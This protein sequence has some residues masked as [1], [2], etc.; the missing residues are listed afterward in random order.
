MGT[1]LT[2]LTPAT[3][4]DALIKV[5]DNGPL[6]GTAKVLS[7][8][9]GNDSIL[10]LSTTAVGIGTTTPSSPLSIVNTIALSA[11]ATN[12]RIFNEAYTINNSGAQT[13]T[14]T[15]IFLNAT[16]TNLNGQTH[17]LIDLQTAS[18]SKFY[19]TNVGFVNANS[20]IYGGGDIRIAAAGQYFW[21]GRSGIKS[22][23]DGNITLLNNANTAFSLLQLGGTTSSFPSIKRNGTAIDFRLADDSG[24]ATLN[25]G[26][27]SCN[28]NFTVTTSMALGGSAL[29]GLNDL[30]SLTASAVLEARSTTK[31]FL[32]PRMTTTQRNAITSPAEG[33]VIYNTTTQKLNLYTTAWEAV[34][35]L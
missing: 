9:L 25:S 26:S 28:S 31:G 24:F 32:P 34:T 12:P 10:A 11:G 2:G 18:I 20:S 17:N 8:G 22:F 7:D 16:E 13:G 15:G 21:N 19:V 29:F 30:G 33:L 3:T 1:S 4:Y 6:S 35:S 5:G 14:A 23:A 27:I